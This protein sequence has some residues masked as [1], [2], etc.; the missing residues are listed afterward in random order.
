MLRAKIVKQTA[1]LY[2]TTTL[3]NNGIVK[4]KLPLHKHENGNGN[5]NTKRKSERVSTKKHKMPRHN[6][7]SNNCE[8]LKHLRCNKP[9]KNQVEP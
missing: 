3:K 2:M 7:K 9:S 1:T 8:K 5:A 4:T 6:V